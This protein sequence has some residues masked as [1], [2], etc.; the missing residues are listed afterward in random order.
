M[1]QE[2]ETLSELGITLPSPAYM[3]GAIVFGLVGLV[4][5]IHGRRVNRPRT[6]WLG[7]ALMLYPYVVWN[8]A[9]LYLVGVGLCVGVWFDW[10]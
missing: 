3:I 8:T 4:A 10:R 7:L 5:Y 9:M 1:Q 2:L 6:R